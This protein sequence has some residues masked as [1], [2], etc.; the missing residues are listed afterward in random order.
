MGEYF[1]KIAITAESTVDLTKELLEKYDIKTLPFTVILGDKSFKDGEEIKPTDI[2]KYVSETKTLPKTSAVN[3]QQY[4]DFFESVL[5]E[6]DAIIHF[7][8][9]SQISSSYSHAVAAA[10]NFKN[11]YIVDTLSLST[12]IAL[13]AINARELAN[14]GL[15]AKEI[16]EKI[17][18]RVPNVQASFVVERLDYLYKG[19][20]CSALALFGAN[21]LK[22]RPQIILKDGKMDAY[23]KY[24]GGM[25]KV[26]ANYS[27]DILEEFNTPDLNVAFVT[28][29]TAT[30]EMICEARKVLEEKGF[31]NIYETT[32]GGTITSHCGEHTLGILY[33][34]DGE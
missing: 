23:R 17:S 31:K 6:Y 2:F 26:I 16:F 21:I 13:L 29:T 8:L 24:R 19:G 28:Y 12:G 10:E 34:N 33:M 15:E 14:K 25:D 11:V 18:A 22:L 30:P 20:R 1:M 27:K 4:N 9:S 5:K 3:E 32:A 7:S